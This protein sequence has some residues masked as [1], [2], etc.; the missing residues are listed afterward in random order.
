MFIDVSNEPAAIALNIR[1][2]KRAPVALSQVR[3][4]DANISMSAG[5]VIRKNCDIVGIKSPLRFSMC[6]V[7]F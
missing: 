3:L 1:M 5:A 4:M 6:D 2:F 7:Q